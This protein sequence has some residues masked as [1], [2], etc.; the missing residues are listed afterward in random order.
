MTDDHGKGKKGAPKE[1]SIDELVEK[2]S[3]EA[4]A[5]KVVKPHRKIRNNYKIGSPVVS[6][7]NAF[8]KQVAGYVRHHWKEHYNGDISEHDA[9]GRAKAILDARFRE[10]GGITHAFGLAKEGKL[11]EVVNTLSAQ[12]E[13][14]STRS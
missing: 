3:P 12:F 1:I 6:D 14:E 2:L 9:F 10:Q 13:A 5:E 4:V 8:V 7:Y 11:D